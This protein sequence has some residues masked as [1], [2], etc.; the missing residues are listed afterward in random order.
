MKAILIDKKLVQDFRRRLF[1]YGIDHWHI[2]PDT[3][4]LGRQMAWQYKNKVG[5]GDIFTKEAH[6]KNS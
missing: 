2:Y 1:K 4:G 5:L 3:Q 6:R